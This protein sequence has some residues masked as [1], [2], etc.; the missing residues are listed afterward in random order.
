MSYR[1][2][3]SE[4]WE[5]SLGRRR[6]RRNDDLQP[7]AGNPLVP[8]FSCLV[9]CM[10]ADPVTA[11][12][13]SALQLLRPLFEAFD[14]WRSA[15]LA[16]HAHRR[17]AKTRQCADAPS[18]TAITGRSE[19]DIGQR[20]GSTLLISKSRG[21]EVATPVATFGAEHA[22]SCAISGRLYARSKRHRCCGGGDGQAFRG[23]GANKAFSHRVRQASKT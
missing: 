9:D 6:S 8:S 1:V 7:R 10:A 22:S 11:V 20:S 14:R 16:V 21:D 13:L 19:I 12:I 3:L 18:A 5:A 15:E 23:A 4:R 17:R 2:S